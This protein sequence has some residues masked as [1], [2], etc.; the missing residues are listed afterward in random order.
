[1]S[2]LVGNL[3]TNIGINIR[4]EGVNE[5]KQRHPYINRITSEKK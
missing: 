2:V 3:F 5:V 1:M 4:G